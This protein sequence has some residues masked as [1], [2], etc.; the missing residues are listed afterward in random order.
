MK[1]ILCHK[2]SSSISLKYEKIKSPIPKKDEVLISVKVAG[3]NFPDVLIVQG[4]YQFKPELPFSPGGEVSGIVKKVGRN[5][6]NLN[7][8]DKVFAG[9]T[10]G[11]FS[12]EAIVMSS[13]TF[14]MPK[15]I[16]YE[17]AAASMVNYGTSYHALLDRAKIKKNEVILIL[18]ASG[19]VGTAAIQIAKEIGAIVIAAASSKEKLDYCKKMGADY[20]IN[21]TKENIK[22]KVKNYT[23]GMGANVI[24]DPVGDKFSEPAL[25][26]IAWEGRYLV[27]GFAAGEIPKIPLNLAL[28]KGCQIIGVFWGLFFRKNPKA[29]AKNFKTI[30]SWIKNKKINVHI[31]KK[32]SL[33]DANKALEYIINRKVKGKILLIP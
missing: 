27:V 13:N 16:S 33:K 18:G 22:E 2:Y 14:K 1:A 9:S 17:D 3:V 21:Y 19:G 6:K 26:S 29:N 31:D 32:F 11:G 25:R 7:V 28:L 10:W 15:E 4:K 8:G 24:Y 30:L 5:V 20:C 12:E 23:K